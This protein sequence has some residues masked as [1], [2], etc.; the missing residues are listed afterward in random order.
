MKALKVTISGSY[1]TSQGEI[2]DFED[3]SGVIPFVD[4]AHAMQ[5]MRRRYAATWI[6]GMRTKDDKKVY[7][8]RI[9]SVRQ[10]FLDDIVETEHNFSYVGKDIREMSFDEI[11]DLG[12]AKD[13]REAPLPKNVSGM[14]LREA[15]EKTY[16]AYS[17]VILRNPINHHL[18]GYNFAKLPKIIVDG[19]IRE[20]TSGK[21]TNDDIIAQ[22]QKISQGTTK[23]ALSMDDLKKIAA[24]RGIEVHHRT[25]FDTLHAQIFG[26]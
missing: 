2:V 10:V 11:Q 3:V 16:L 20:E 24:D 12:T 14:S 15:R 8:E 21:I 26:G 19:D 18:E 5:V 17:K 7:P 1:K 4:E 9:D 22:E 23:T 13:L 25:G 6:S